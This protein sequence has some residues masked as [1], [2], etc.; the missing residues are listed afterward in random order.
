MSYQTE[1]PSFG[2]LDVV[3]PIGFTDISWHN[4]CCPSF[5]RQLPDGRSTRIWVDFADPDKRE[6]DGSRFALC[7]YNAD[8]EWVETLIETNDWSNIVSACN[9]QEVSE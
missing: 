5:E 2:I 8:G 3:L 6:L 9:L 7:V 1:F 4:D